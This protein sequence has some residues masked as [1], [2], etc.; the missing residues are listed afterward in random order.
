MIAECENEQIQL[1]WSIANELLE[2][3]NNNDDKT[4]FEE[5][6]R[7]FNEVRQ[8]QGP[9]LSTNSSRKNRRSRSSNQKATTTHQVM[10][11]LD[12][13]LPL[14]FLLDYLFSINNL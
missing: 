10:S 6:K 11:F 13:Y 8:Q 5:F 4:R 14:I 7:R 9:L 1:M 12:F 3:S 2:I